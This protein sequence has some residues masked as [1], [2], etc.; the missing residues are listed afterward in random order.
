[1]PNMDDLIIPIMSSGLDPQPPMGALLRDPRAGQSHCTE[2]RDLAGTRGQP[3]PG[4]WL[5]PVPW[6]QSF[7]VHLILST[8]VDEPPPYT[9]STHSEQNQTQ[10]KG[11][12]GDTRTSCTSYQVL[13]ALEQRRAELSTVWFPKRVQDAQS[14]S[15]LKELG[16]ALIQAITAPQHI[17]PSPQAAGLQ[18]KEG[19]EMSP[20]L[21]KSIT[22]QSYLA[23]SCCTRVPTAAEDGFGIVGLSAGEESMGDASAKGVLGGCM[24]EVE[25][26]EMVSKRQV[27]ARPCIPSANR[28]RSASTCALL[29]S[30]RGVHCGLDE[31][32]QGGKN[33]LG[34]GKGGSRGQS[35]HL[36]VPVSPC[37]YGPVPSATLS[38]EPWG[39]AQHWIQARHPSRRKPGSRL[40]K[41]LYW[42]APS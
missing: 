15:A 1:M 24:W 13:P 20:K 5:Q 14:G 8:S 19:W 33:S 27:M 42:S 25:R 36:P 34:E 18:G 31:F 26:G 12:A 7:S 9:A 17:P 30:G 10:G 32:R 11:F 22:A 2:L 16:S 3:G 29:S 37:L 38:Q 39:H 6:G 4:H 23:A 35:R 21:N 41:F 40:L 28:S